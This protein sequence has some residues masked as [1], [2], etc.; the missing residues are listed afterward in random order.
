MNRTRTS[1]SP[2]LV[3]SA[4]WLPAVLSFVAA[5]GFGWNTR[6]LAFF[7]VL[8]AMFVGLSVDRL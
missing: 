4:L 5:I 2:T 6:D 1:L 8:A 3:A 7:F